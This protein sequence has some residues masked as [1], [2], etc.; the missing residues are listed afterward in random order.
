MRAR[1]IVEA[2]A[3]TPPV[4]DLAEKAPISLGRNP[5]SND[6]ILDDRYASK[7][8]AE[9]LPDED[10][11]VLH[12]CNSTN[13]TRLNNRLLPKGA[14][15]PLSDGDLITVGEVRLRFQL[16]TTL[17][18]ITDEMPV[19]PAPPQETA[20]NEDS[21]S[22]TDLQADALAA[23]LDY[24]SVA[25]RQTTVPDLVHCALVVICRHT[26]ATSAGYVSFEADE[27]DLKIVFPVQ[28]AVDTPLSRRLSRRVRSD[29]KPLWLATQRNSDLEGESLLAIRD[30]LCLPLRAGPARGDEVLGALHVY[31]SGGAFNERQARFCEVLANYLSGQLQALRAR[32]ALEADYVRLRGHIGPDKERL[33][34]DSPA[35]CQ[36]RDQIARLADGPRVV[37]VTGESGV[38]KELVAM[39]LH[40]QSRRARGPMVTRSCADLAPTVVES[41][42]FGHKKGSFTGATEDRAGCFEQADE[43]TLFLDEVGEL[44]LEVQGK[45]L[46]V[47]EAR[48]V[49]PL[50]STEKPVDVRIIF[51]TNRDLHREVQQGRFRSDLF[52][53][54]T[55]TLRVPPLREHLEDVPLLAEH[56]LDC[57]AAEYHR[58]PSLTEAAVERLMNYSWPGNVRQL[59]CV[60]ETAV[61]MSDGSH[62]LNAGDLHLIDP[63]APASDGPPSLNIEEVEAWLIRKAMAKHPGNKAQAARELGIHRDTLYA[64]LS[65]YGIE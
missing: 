17:P 41:E 6:V 47:L 33:L 15:A 49:T 27:P 12:D 37:L 1:L 35:M 30:A 55:S 28:A 29:G 60:L 8:H 63:T 2:G 23:L 44:P 24:M 11:W 34:G 32:R 20:S 13:R 7:R 40:R 43:G 51:A 3:A 26:R 65:K 39:S 62:P 31:L 46:R 45:L 14:T 9:I 4:C 52:F 53:R 10:G 21:L 59:R 5:R 58:R 50:G 42:L 56:F 36:L 54:I 61:T 57:L 16:S 22:D 64:K 48:R 38:G 25:V 19:V 18:P